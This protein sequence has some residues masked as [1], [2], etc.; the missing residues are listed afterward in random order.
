MEKV[1]CWIKFLFKYCDEDGDEAEHQHKHEL[2]TMETTRTKI[3]RIILL[4]FLLSICYVCFRLPFYKW[5]FDLSKLLLGFFFSCPLASLF[6]PPIAT[7]RHWTSQEQC[8]LSLWRQF[9]IMQTLIYRWDST[10]FRTKQFIKWNI[11]RS[12]DRNGG[13]GDQ[14]QS[15]IRAGGQKGCREKKWNKYLTLKRVQCNKFQ[16]YWRFLFY[17]QLRPFAALN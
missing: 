4:L 1:I 16:I 12:R 9:D 14:T 8:K 3:K 11:L 15:F 7:E 13:G 10:P 17:I 2:K 5:L 6:S